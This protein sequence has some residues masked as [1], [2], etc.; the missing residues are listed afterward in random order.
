MVTLNI[1][2]HCDTSWIHYSALVSEVRSTI[3]F[4]FHSY[5]NSYEYT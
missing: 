4:A 3:F 1:L 2:T 5:M